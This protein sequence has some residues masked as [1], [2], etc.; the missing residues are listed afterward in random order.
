MKAVAGVTAWG[1]GREC[2][3]VARS[4][5]WPRIAHRVRL[6]TTQQS[7]PR[8]R[9]GLPMY[10][11]PHTGIGM[12]ILTVAAVIITGVERVKRLRRRGRRHR[13]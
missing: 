2:K 3:I 6:G 5:Q 4:G 9:E 13:S 1:C 11:Q 12:I 7:Q 10:F 8:V